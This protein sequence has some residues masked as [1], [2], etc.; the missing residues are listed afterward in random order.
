MQVIIHVGPHKTGTTAIQGFLRR[1]IDFLGESGVHVPRTLT[2]HAGHHEIPW[3]LLG[4]PI[5]L[6]GDGIESS[7]LDR[8]VEGALNDATAAGCSKTLFSSEDFS[9]LNRAQWK[10]LLATIYSTATKTAPVS[11]HIVTVYRNPEEYI[12]SQY[13]TLVLLGLSQELGEVTESLRAHFLEV[14]QM[15]QSLT[16]L[17]EEVTEVTQLAYRDDG[18]VSLFC[19]S[20]FPG[21]IFPDASSGEIRVNQSVDDFI[22]EAIRQGNVNSGVEFDTNHLLHWPMFQKANSGLMLSERARKLFAA[23][24]PL[25]AERDSLVGERDSLVGERDSL[26]GERDLLVGERDLLVNS[27][28][29]RITKPLRDIARALR[30]N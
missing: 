4:W 22:I 26:V 25:L 12:S 5:E 14:H 15:L 24:A 20:L 16:H 19:D 21:L 23:H 6:L 27:H 17:F 7:S 9:L 18:M 13:K 30:G 29:W 1:N 10:D 11:V 28:S 8:F 2:T 3:T